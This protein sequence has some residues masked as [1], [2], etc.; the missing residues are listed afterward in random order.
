MNAVT[1]T[2]AERKVYYGQRGTYFYHWLAVCA[3]L[4]P[5]EQKE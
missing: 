3:S 4:A 5:G 1:R 2:L